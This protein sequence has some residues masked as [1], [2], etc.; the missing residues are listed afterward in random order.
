[1]G[2]IKNAT[3]LDLSNQG[4]TEIPEYVFVCRNLQRLNLSN[5]KI[6]EIPAR[7]AVLKRLK[8]LDLSNNS[9]K[10]LLSRFFNL[11]NLQTLNLNHNQLKTLPK[12]IGKL[13]KLK[14]LLMNANQLASLPEELG[15]LPEILQLSL[16]ENK[17]I[18]FPSVVLK[19]QNLTHLWIGKNNFDTIPV[20]EIAEE[21]NNLKGIYVFNSQKNSSVND[22]FTSS[23]FRKKGNSLEALKL[24]AYTDP[25]G[26][27][28]QARQEISRK[29]RT[30]FISY[31]HRDLE[32]KEEVE[33][34]LNGLKNIYPDLQFEFWADDK[35]KSGEGWENEIQA[36]LNRS[37]IAILI[38]SRN[39]IA[40]D[41]IMKTEVSS[42]L[43]NVEEKGVLVLT[44][45]AGES[46][47]NKSPIGKFQW[48]NDPTRPLKSLRPHEQDAVYNKLASRIVEYFS[49]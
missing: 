40:S 2:N 18:L 15:S 19:M 34:S 14:R 13:T 17:L 43:K 29:P 12:Q 3:K 5:N 30:I 22:I 36:A 23:L 8:T 37:A 20:Y 39:F 32:Y 24:L 4:L 9:I 31:S 33:I 42:I 10:Q 48:I 1:M 6:T 21:L 26:K 11:Q 27:T 41:F 46:M 47:L 49:K 28:M 16:S 44:I 45:V 38:A 25:K 7:L 35:I